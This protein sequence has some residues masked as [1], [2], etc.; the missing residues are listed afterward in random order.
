MKKMKLFDLHSN[1]DATGTAVRRG[2][3]NEEKNIDFNSYDVW[4][5]F[6]QF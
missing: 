5:V 3:E 6:A 2:R 4:F 1:L